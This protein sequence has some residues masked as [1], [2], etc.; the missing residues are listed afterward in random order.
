MIYDPVMDRKFKAYVLCYR[1]D[2]YQV[3]LGVMLLETCES[4]IGFAD[5]RFRPDLETVLER[6]PDAD[7]DYL[8]L[9]EE[10]LRDML[11]SRRLRRQFGAGPKV[12]ARDWIVSRILEDFSNTI[13]VLEPVAVCTDPAGSPEEELLKL[14]RMYTCPPGRP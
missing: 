12:S 6:D 2:S 9:L 8:R 11:R 1:W 10:E 3:N 7:L 5:L 14:L 4:E 13:T